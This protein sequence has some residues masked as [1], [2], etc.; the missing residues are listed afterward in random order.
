MA[1]CWIWMC[2]AMT[3][4]RE[5][6]APGHQSV[7]HARQRERK[8]V[9]CS[10]RMSCSPAQKGVEG[11]RT[12]ASREMTVRLI[13]QHTPAG[14]AC[15]IYGGGLRQQWRGWACVG[16]LHTL[17]VECVCGSGEGRGSECDRAA[18]LSEEGVPYLRGGPTPA[19]AWVGVCGVFTHTRGRVCVW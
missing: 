10:V 17:E 8:W 12:G 7:V 9:G 15:L 2:E 5:W 13:R 3:R 18:P 16:C 1:R 19:M 11:A 6:P 4:P 14:R